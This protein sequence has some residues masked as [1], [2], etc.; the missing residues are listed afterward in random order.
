MEPLQ[1]DAATQFPR[2]LAT[3]KHLAP[4]IV[5]AA[6]LVSPAIGLSLW[7]LQLD[8]STLFAAFVGI[9]G[10]VVALWAWRSQRWPVVFLG[11]YIALAFGLRPLQTLADPSLISAAVPFTK[12]DLASGMVTALMAVSLG[13]VSF[14][15]VYRVFEG[16]RNSVVEES[17]QVRSA[18]IRLGRT[19]VVLAVGL[20]CSYA[21]VQT[22]GGFTT[23]IVSARVIR[24]NFAGSFYPL[25]GVWVMQSAGLALYAFRKRSGEPAGVLPYLYVG[26]GLVAG[27]VTGSRGAATPLLV[28]LIVLALH[29]ERGKGRLRIIAG[30]VL[31]LVAIVAYGAYKQYSVP[32]ASN[33]GVISG[34]NVSA[35]VNESDYFALTVGRRS[36]LPP[37]GELLGSAAS[38]PTYLL[39]RAIYPNKVEPY[40]YRVRAVLLGGIVETGLP[41]SLFG[42]AWLI[43]G[44]VGVT[45]ISGLAGAIMGLASRALWSPSLRAQL[46][47][48]VIV[49]SAYLI[50]SRP[51]VISISRLLSLLLAMLI[52]LLIVEVR[53]AKPKVGEG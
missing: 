6:T 7:W 50:L 52:A 13:F 18:E 53:S 26:L 44:H 35:Q 8:G 5:I 15:F 27:L 12:S 10:A 21:L 22:A 48:A 3:R 33:V 16:V 38:A 32:G 40:D 29:H 23:A 36:T 28:A 17:T 46:F 11:L 41:I 20:V 1:S 43:G 39:P 30:G 4:S 37:P 49:G 51:M 45:I 47:G 14:L 25:F 19:F 31:L 2:K 24:G 9:V 42:E 34:A